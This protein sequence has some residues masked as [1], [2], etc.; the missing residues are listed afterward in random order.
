M[1]SRLMMASTTSP[2]FL[3][4]LRVPPLASTSS[5]RYFSF[6]AQ[7]SCNCLSLI[8]RMVV[9]RSALPLAFVALCHSR[10]RV[11]P[12]LCKRTS[13][14]PPSAHA[15]CSAINS[16]FPSLARKRRPPS[17]SPESTLLRTVSE[18]SVKLPSGSTRYSAISALAFSC[19]AR[20]LG[21]GFLQFASTWQRRLLWPKP[22][23]RILQFGET[24]R[25]SIGITQSVRN[26]RCSSCAQRISA[27]SAKNSHVP[28]GTAENAH[29]KQSAKA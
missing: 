13:L 29:E 28:T 4:R 27:L 23:P 16:F 5:L 2:I 21:S 8:P 10:K 11:Q 9:C 14:P 3:A 25:F 7:S 6:C 19:S 18:S 22:I 12:I 15:W 24:P 20:I 1:V 17:T 26:G